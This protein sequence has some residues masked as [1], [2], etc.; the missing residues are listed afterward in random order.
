M[1]RLQ[2]YPQMHQCHNVQKSVLRPV[3][4]LAP[5][6]NQGRGG[7]G[8]RKFLRKCCNKD[9]LDGTKEPTRSAHTQQLN[10]RKIG[11]HVNIT[12][13]FRQQDKRC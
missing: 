10:S 11:E 13:G 5:C 8:S 4:S 9:L 2:F 3:A 6:H 7:G 12:F 1:S